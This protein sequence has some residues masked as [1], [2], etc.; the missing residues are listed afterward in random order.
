MMSCLW[1]IQLILKGKYMSFA[2][3]KKNRSAAID[4]LKNA[5][6]KV[7][8]GEQKS[9]GDDRLW[10]PTVDKS[11]N[12]YAVIRFLPAGE[13]EDL[14]W[15][16][17]WD[18][19]FKGPTGRWYIERS[20]T[21]IGQPDPV[22]EINSVLWNTGRDEDKA[23]ARDRKRRLHYV[24]N[25]YVVS[26]PSNPDNDGKVFL[27]Q[28]GKKIFDKITDIMTPQ[29]QDEEPVNP[30]D[31]WEGSNFKLKIRNVEGYRNYD[32]SEF[33][34][35]KPLSDDESELEGIYNKLHSLKEFND[36]SAYKSYAELK[37]KLSQ[38]LGDDGMSMTTAESISLDETAELR[39]KAPA[40]AREPVL[41]TK[42][43]PVQAS[44]DDDDDTLSYFAKLAA[45]S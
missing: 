18:H 44:E 41:M 12:G 15:V 6:E 8:G 39:I 32:K 3:L 30:F 34:S 10:K 40:P 29:F 24:A 16:R 4:K 43:E 22:S 42:A 33:D 27:F 14:P 23:I 2:S 7:G 11:G 21:S 17:Y 45:Q 37:A 31:F 20:L 25:I 38:V 5:A 36:P 35:P 9:Y 13:G 26:D 1:I 28:F 19:G